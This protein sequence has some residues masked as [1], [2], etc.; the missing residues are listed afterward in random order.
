[1]DGGADTVIDALKGVI[2]SGGVLMMPAF[3][4]P[5][6]EIFE[7]SKTPTTMGIICE[8]FRKQDDVVRSL[9]PTHSV[10]VWGRDAHTYADAH[11]TATALGVGSPVHRLI[12][13]GGEILLLGVG[14]WA[15]SIVHVA[16]AMARVPYLDLPYNDDF[17]KE[18][19]M[20][21]PDGSLEAVPPREN[22][23][24]SVNFVTV[25]QPLKEAGLITYHRVGDT[26]LQRID[27]R[28]A[29]ELLS[30]L[31][32]RE[33]DAFLCSWELCPFCPRARKLVM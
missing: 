5:P 2:T 24:C 21:L 1:M 10:A 17:A 26:L 30:G 8:T 4:F 32:K 31:L 13:D 33:P 18:L 6:A 9:H 25:E 22:P 16:E 28:G 15:N 7:P 11:R 3:T 20:R 14:H 19:M 29:I 27:G 23:G 12:E